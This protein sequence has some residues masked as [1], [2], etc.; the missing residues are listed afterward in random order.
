[1]WQRGQRVPVEAYLDAYPMLRDQAAILILVRSE[2]LLR[3][4]RGERPSLAE[5][6]VRFPA[7][8][9]AL[10]RQLLEA[11]LAGSSAWPTIPGY[12]ILCELGRGGMGVVFK[13][14]QSRLDRLVALKMIRD[15]TLCEP[16]LLQRFQ[17]EAQAVARMQHPNIVQ[18]FEIGLLEGGLIPF[19]SLEFVDGGHLGDYLTERPLDARQ[20]AGLVQTLARAIHYAHERDIIH[21]DLKPANIL[22]TLDGQPKV[23]DFG[24]AKHLDAGLLP[25]SAGC[26]GPIP[27][28]TTLGTVLGTPEYMA[29]EQALAV[30]SVGPA[31]DI[32]ALGVIL[33]EMLTGRCPFEGS[34]ALETIDQLRH[35]DPV[36]PR[37]LR[38]RTPRDLETIALK[39]LEKD[40]QRRYATARALA[41]DLERFANHRPIVARPPDFCGRALRWAR[42]KPAIAVLMGLLVLTVSVSLAGISAALL[43][44]LEGWQTAEIQKGE[45]R[46]RAVEASQQQGLAEKRQL[47]AEQSLYLNCIASARLEWR[48]ANYDR[49]LHQLNLCLRP[50]EMPAAPG[51]DQ[52][53]WEWYFLQGLLHGDLYT[54]TDPHE[55]ST[56]VLRFTRDG[57]ALVSAG[58]NPFAKPT[59]S[60]KVWHA[61][62]YR[63]R[64][65]WKLPSNVVAMDLSADDRR[66]VCLGLDRIV[67]I[68]GLNDFV[69]IQTF[70]E[71]YVGVACVPEKHPDKDCVVAV[72]AEGVLHVRDSLTSKSIRVLPLWVSGA[73]QP[74]PAVSPNPGPPSNCLAFHPNGTWLAVSQRN[75]VQI[76]D[77]V[78]GQSIGIFK[79]PHLNS[80]SNPAFSPD[81]QLLAVG[82]STQ[83]IVWDVSTGQV[84]STLGG[85]TSAVTA[86]AF[87]PDG[88]HLATGSADRTVRVWL[89]TNG[90]EEQVFIGHRGRVKSLLYHRNGRVLVSGGEQPAEI[91]VWDVTR[92]QEVANLSVQNDRHTGPDEAIAFSPDSRSLLR[93]GR[94][95]GGN[96]EVCDAASGTPLSAR[97][98]PLNP[99]WRAPAAEAAFSQQHPQRLATV[100]RDPRRVE[101]RAVDKGDV[102]YAVEFPFPVARLALSAD[103]RRLAAASGVS[104][105]R[106]ALADD[107][108]ARD[109]HVCDLEAGKVLARFR[110]AFFPFEALGLARRFHGVLALNK[111]GSQVAFDDYP[112]TKDLAD[113]QALVHVHQV[114]TSSLRYTVSG[115]DPLVTAL[116][117]SPSGDYLAS[118]SSSGRDHG[119]HVIV[120]NL[121]TGRS[122][123]PRPLEGPAFVYDL[124]F[125]PGEKRLAL[126]DREQIYLWDVVS[127]QELFTLRGT[128]VRL[129]DNGFN[130]RVVWSLDGRHLAANGW[131]C[132][133]SVWSAM[134]QQSGEA[135]RQQQRLYAERRKLRWHIKEAQNAHWFAHAVHFHHDQTAHLEPQFAQDRLE[136]ARLAVRVGAWDEALADFR[137]AWSGG[138]HNTGAPEIAGADI[139]LLWH[140]Y[141]LLLLHR[142]YVEESKRVL[143]GMKERFGASDN[144]TA[145]RWLAL[146][147]GLDARLGGSGAEMLDWIGR[148]APG[149][150]I[151][152]WGF[153]TALAQY[154]AGQYALASRTLE[155]SLKRAEDPSCQFQCMLLQALAYQQGRETEK[156]RQCL[157][158]AEKEIEER[159][160]STP[161]DKPLL[162]P[163]NTRW[164]EW[165]AIQLL[166]RE[167]R[168]LVQ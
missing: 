157:L 144:M 11:P 134:D 143:I 9:E 148:I 67:R 31:A 46:E 137:K 159:Q 103:G 64:G 153:V 68:Y 71:G 45:A 112:A 106:L 74:R 37:R 117:F 160:R 81:G 53:Q 155:E 57:S 145:I 166:L 95:A 29:P 129:G 147:A 75:Q 27:P 93:L 49:S 136:R 165:V 80:S 168:S 18:I 114:D 73:P 119:T 17:A 13:A 138:S 164:Y 124:A 33:Y 5:Y 23:S 47:Q 125:H 140:E 4:Q 63:S 10:G 32:Y 122:L 76:V 78:S 54:L 126:A 16:E 86:V 90:R 161:G 150:R 39:C 108:P 55:V 83:A 22:M 107:K 69:P 123:H 1:M 130:P 98:V 77:T 65:Q 66:A 135:H 109:V 43:Y 14:K 139:P 56:N 42:R 82:N 131:D 162:V 146:T 158:R 92:T 50:S 101:V 110:Q 41:E 40:P 61:E 96:L 19:F 20:A 149:P 102:L 100:L 62:S 113:I 94:D 167:A 88:I 118:A 97:N 154:R 60:C 99:E 34:N 44:A 70:K 59:G 128:P 132:T 152:E 121:A 91:K 141:A 105:P 52:R 25:S 116:A 163:Q 26:R 58:G 87:S 111:D 142:G 115:H 6:E 79:G 2:F 120:T 8:S 72:N 24:L 51:S 156:A 48:G 36:P 28:A 127:G 151:P 3:Q 85:H 84:Q 89:T 30:G 133:V 7:L 35:H 38:P 15:G 21:R 12:E 104:P